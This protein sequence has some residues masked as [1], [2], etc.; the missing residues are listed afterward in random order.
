MLAL[1]LSWRRSFQLSRCVPLR[2]PRL[3]RKLFCPVSNPRWWAVASNCL[4][5]GFGAAH[6]SG[7]RTVAI[8]SLPRGCRKRSRSI[9]TGCSAPRSY[10]QKLTSRLAPIVLPSWR[11]RRAAV[12]SLTREARIIR[13]S[14]KWETPFYCFTWEQTT[15]APRLLPKTRRYGA[16]R[17]ISPPGHANAL[18]WP[19]ANSCAA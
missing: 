18:G 10:A 15:M 14:A 7:A 4:I 3:R 5:I 9:P 11:C 8:T 12:T 6:R 16:R 13:T 19:R 2:R 1:P 17:V